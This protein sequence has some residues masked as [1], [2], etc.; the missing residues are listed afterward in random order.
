MA[1]LTADRSDPIYSHLLS[2]DD[3]VPVAAS[4]TLYL[5]SIVG[6]DADGYLTTADLAEV[7]K[8]LFVHICSKVD[9]SA[10]VDGDRNTRILSHGVAEFPQGGLVQT[11]M[12]KDIH[13]TDD[14]TLTNLVV[15]DKRLGVLVGLKN[16]RAQ[17]R[18][19]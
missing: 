3:D 13:A 6:Y 11:D 14:S 16:N 9:N 15:T 10:G 12:G 2:S 4:T 1:N 7:G 8:P 18:L 5:G 19:G 17:I